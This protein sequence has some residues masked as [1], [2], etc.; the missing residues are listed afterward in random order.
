[1]RAFRAADV[2]PEFHFSQRFLQVGAQDD[3]N[4]EVTFVADNKGLSRGSARTLSRSDRD[5]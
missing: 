2:E 1:M 4:D 3:A 5:S